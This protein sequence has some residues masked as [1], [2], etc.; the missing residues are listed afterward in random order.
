MGFGEK[1]KKGITGNGRG[2]VMVGR[3]EEWRGMARKGFQTM[4][5]WMGEGALEF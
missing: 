2:M 3:V 4:L 1:I 5:G